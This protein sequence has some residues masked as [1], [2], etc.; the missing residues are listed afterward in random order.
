MRRLL[1]A[2]AASVLLLLARG[3]SAEDVPVATADE[4]LAAIAAA[5]PGDVIVV[6]D[7]TYALTGA[8]CTADGTED[9]PIVVRGATHL[10]ALIELDSLEGFRVSG[11]HWH[12]EDLDVQGVC[13]SD[14]DCEHAF[15][16]TGGAEGFVLRNS[17]VRDF[18][19]QLKVNAQPDDDGVYHIPHRGLIEGNELR[20]TSPRE[21]DAP[22]TKL[23]IDT[24][25]GWI[26]RANVIADFHKNGGNGI[27]YGAFMK[28]GGSG[29]LFERN[30]VLCTDAVDTGGTRIGLSFGG[31]GTGAQFC[32]PE[33]DP[34]VDCDPEHT[35]GVMRNNVIARCSDVGIYLNLAANT[36]VLHNTLIDTAGIDFRF[37]STTGEADGNVLGGDIEGREGGTFTAGTNVQGVTLD[38]FLAV[39]QAPLAG[40]LRVIGDVS[41]WEGAGA[42]RDDVPDDYCLRERPEGPTTLGALEHSLGSCETVPPPLG[43]SASAGSG[44]G[45]P[46]GSGGSSGQGGGSSGEGAGPGSGGDAASPA[47]GP[48]ST[49][50]GGL[51]ATGTGGASGDGVA[52]DDDG[53]GC[54]LAGASP[55]EPGGALALLALAA[56]G[57]ARLRR[58]ARRRP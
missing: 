47:A 1:A 3:A 13:G 14:P 26:V 52:A 43:E 10:G 30:L 36:K 39:Y 25:D 57:A 16:V 7:G 51:T 54:R 11:A 19:A 15:H 58:P 12:F 29:G 33:F 32:A 48:G 8:S 21:T 31:G 5:A 34:D 27:S 50:S 42:A 24:G 49:T 35:D 9:Q 23:N 18:N 45:G 40:D 20:D 6:A 44:G 2:P 28:S 22:V 37:E 56:A 4:L 55:A 38:A 17:R 53:C 46:A 41:A